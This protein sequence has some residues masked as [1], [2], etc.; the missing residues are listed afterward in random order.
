[1]NQY[2]GVVEIEI[3]GEKRGFKFGMACTAMLCKIEG[4]SLKEVQERLAA[5]DQSTMCNMY[6]AAAVQYVRLKNTEQ[7][8]KV[9]EPTFEEV[10]NWIDNMSLTQNEDAVKTAFAQYE[11][12]NGK[13]PE[14]AGQ[15]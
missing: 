4:C 6:Y 12:P 10:A 2:K 11:D 3:L 9:K 5:N 1:M 7:T 14:T 13:A 15:S 8:E